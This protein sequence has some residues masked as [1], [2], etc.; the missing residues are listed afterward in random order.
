[1]LVRFLLL[2]GVLVATGGFLDTWSSSKPEPW[3]AWAMHNPK[4]PKPIDH[5]NWAKI[6]AKYVYTDKSGLNRFRYS[7]VTAQD[8]ARLDAYIRTLTSIAIT[9]RARDVQLAYW[10]NLYNA[11][12]V[13]VV[14][15]H[16]PVK[17]IRDIDISGVLSDGPWGKKLASIEGKQVSLDDIEHRILRPIWQDPRIHYSVNC[18]SVGCPNLAKQPYTAANVNTLL[19]KAARTY[20]NSPRGFS[21]S[22]GKVTVSKIY[23][24]FAYDFGD[25]ERGVIDH[26]NRYASSQRAAELNKIGRISSTQYN[27][28]L[29]E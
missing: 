5:S 19:D 29:N 24:W 7:T 2:F 14:L 26:L 25:S 20:V 9:K 12:T 3:Q 16:Y 22:N 10:I 28:K 15:D 6:L 11:L 27:W 18:A 13:K 23:S 4:D 8:K 17:S 1:M 21:I